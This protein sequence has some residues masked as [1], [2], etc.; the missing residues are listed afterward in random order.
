MVVVIIKGEKSEKSYCLMILFQ[1][2]N[3][4]EPME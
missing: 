4:R 2:L 3:G 1:E